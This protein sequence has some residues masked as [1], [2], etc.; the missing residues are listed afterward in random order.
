MKNKNY[1]IILLHGWGIDGTRYKEVKK[2]LSEKEYT[3]YTPDLPGFGSN[4]Q[5]KEYYTLEDYAEFLYQFIRDHNLDNIILIGHSNG[6]RVISKY[7]RMF[8]NSQEIEK[9]KGIIL[10][11]TPLVRVPLSLRKKV[12]VIISKI[13][14]KI[15]STLPIFNNDMIVQTL[16][17]YLYRF[18][19]EV[20][21]YKAG[22]MRKT[23][24]MILR[25]RV[26]DYLS[27]FTIPTLILWGR[28][29]K[30]TP[31]SMAY[32]IHSKIK[33]SKIITVANATHKLPYEFPKV[34]ADNIIEFI[35]GIK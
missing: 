1:S 7:L 26:E 19:G 4:I 10:S 27:Y 23:L 5:E 31:I 29:D 35:R 2:L 17:K 16:K 22:K 13:G 30:I 33:N 6:G 14:K 24:S 11:G 21:Y 8:Q 3:V 34:F 28:D 12:G 15:V 25:E 20:D 18:I 9:I 32:Q